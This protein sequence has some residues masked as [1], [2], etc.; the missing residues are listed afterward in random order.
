MKSSSP[1]SKKKSRGRTVFG[2]KDSGKILHAKAIR[3]GQKHHDAGDGDT[4]ITIDL[5][6]GTSFAQP[7]VL[8]FGAVTVSNAAPDVDTLVYNVKAG[9]DALGRVRDALVKPGV[10][11]GHKSEVPK[12]RVDAKDP[13]TLIREVNGRIDRGHIVG[14]TFVPAE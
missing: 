13:T 10:T 5:A 8:R 7:R 12:F 2:A 11:L 9:R 6:A 1:V 4:R 3:A 14:G